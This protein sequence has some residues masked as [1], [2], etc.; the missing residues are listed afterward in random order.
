[1]N[2]KTNNFILNR[3]LKTPIFRAFQ[4]FE[5]LAV[6]LAAKNGKG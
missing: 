3:L 2:D 1:M 5:P 4:T 6:W